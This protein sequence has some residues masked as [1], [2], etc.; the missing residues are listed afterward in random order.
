MEMTNQRAPL[1]RPR[2]PS[3]ITLLEPKLLRPWV[4]RTYVGISGMR[5][6][7]RGIFPTLCSCDASQVVLAALIRVVKAA[8]SNLQ[9]VASAPSAGS[10]L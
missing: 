5:R 10:R 6:I 8:I 7:A 1:V 2:G 9:S 3:K 4:Q